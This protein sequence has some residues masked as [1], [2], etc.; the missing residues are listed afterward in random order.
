MLG[1]ETICVDYLLKKIIL[2]LVYFPNML[3]QFASLI[4]NQT[5]AFLTECRAHPHSSVLHQQI[6]ACCIRWEVNN[7][8]AEGSYVFISIL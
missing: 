8:K 6:V 5:V 2:P 1:K 4:V 7:Y 3:F